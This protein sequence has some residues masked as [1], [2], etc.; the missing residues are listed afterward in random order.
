MV[1]TWLTHGENMVKTE[2]SGELTP[3]TQCNGGELTPLT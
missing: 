3:L 2:K 1:K